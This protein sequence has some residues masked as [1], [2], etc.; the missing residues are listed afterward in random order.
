M[1]SIPIDAPPRTEILEPDTWRLIERAHAERAD[2]FT[3]GHRER[4]GTGRTH[5]IEDFLFTYYP[6]KPSRLRVWHPGAGVVLAG[7]DRADVRHYVQTRDGATLDAAAFLAANTVNVGFV[8]GLLRGT[9]SRPARFSCFGMHEWAMVYRLDPAEL[10]HTGLPL[11][12]GRDET[13]AVVE[14]HDIACTHID[15]Y[16]FFTPAAVPRNRFA[17]TRETQPDLEQGGCLHAGMDLYKWAAKL[18]PAVEGELL[19]DAFELARDIRVLDMRASPYDVSAYGHTPVAVETP[20][21]K[22][23]YAT[24]QRGFAARGA[25]LRN[26]LLT[27]IT[28]LRAAA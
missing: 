6:F 4:R 1:S 13:D 21:G 15:A 24:A 11:R 20:E 22:R 14:A 3:A 19:L 17:P 10:R 27:S 8:E 23:E 2:A 26:R 25:E 7:A 18:G 16:R 5:P 28:K 9:A 12:L